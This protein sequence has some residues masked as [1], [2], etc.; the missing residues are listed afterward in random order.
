MNKNK[1]IIGIG[2]ILAIVLGVAV[3]GGGAYYL[4]KSNFKQE[5]Q[6]PE[7]NQNKNLPI[8]E[9]QTELTIYN[10]STYGY[11][12]GYSGIDFKSVY[13]DNNGKGVR[14]F[15][16]QSNIDDLEVVDS[17]F[18]V[19]NYISSVGIVTFGTNQ[20][21]KFKD[22]TTPRH[23]YYLISGLKNNKSI[24]ISIENN[25]DVPNYFDLASLKINTINSGKTTTWLK[26]PKVGLYY[27]DTL[28]IIE[29]YV[30]RYGKKVDSGV[31]VE[32]FYAYWGDNQDSGLIWGGNDE[33]TNP[34]VGG[35]GASCMNDDSFGVFQYGVSS[36]TCLKGKVTRVF[37]VSAR[38]KITEDDLKV[39]GDFVL[40][41]RQ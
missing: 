8:V 28:N 13:I 4:G 33:A 11:S 23:T 9:T 35:G 24:L 27:Q 20:Y 34:T 3:V 16:N 14:L 5:A 38:N 19:P 2:L 17:S 41:N 15:P 29:Y 26:S 10:S 30:D 21:K 32:V 36:M 1:G 25:S 40:K 37:H 6:N 22:D 18:V 31:G 12:I 39:F 7:I